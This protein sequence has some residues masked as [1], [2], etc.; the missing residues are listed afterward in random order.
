MRIEKPNRV[1]RTFTQQ[2]VAEPSQ[3]FPLLCPVREA[4][5]LEDWDPLVVY[6]QSGVAEADCV[7]LTEAGST[8]AIWYINKHEPDNG[9]VEMIKITP[10]VT[11]CKLTIQLQP[12]VAGSTATVSYTHTSLG[13]EGDTFIASFTEEFYKEFMQD[14]E[15]RINHYLRHGTVLRT[16]G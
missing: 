6:C 7:F 16:D 2:L 8:G 15:R 1:T 3:V 14:W 12:A 4:D 9:L 11:A 10:D 5:W 13:Q